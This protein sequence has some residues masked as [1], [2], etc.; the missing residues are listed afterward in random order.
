MWAVV[1]GTDVEFEPPLH[2]VSNVTATRGVTT[3]VLTASRD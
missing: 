1:D 3:R 2:P